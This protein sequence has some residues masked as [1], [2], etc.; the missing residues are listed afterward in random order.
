MHSASVL[1]LRSTYP[2]WYA[3]WQG[4]FLNPCA[5]H[6]PLI[7][8]PNPMELWSDLRMEETRHGFMENPIQT[9]QFVISSWWWYLKNGNCTI[10]SGPDDSKPLYKEQ[11]LRVSI[12]R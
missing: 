4:Q 12:L 3:K 5:K 2:S 10:G 6:F 1:D 9:E 8:F 11:G 7:E